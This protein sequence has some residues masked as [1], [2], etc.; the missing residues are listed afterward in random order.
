L[1]VLDIDGKVVLRIILGKK[2]GNSYETAMLY[3]CALLTPERRN[4]ITKKSAISRQWL[5]KQV[6]AATKA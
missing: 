3:F 6:P 2:L 1:R 5:S 4:H